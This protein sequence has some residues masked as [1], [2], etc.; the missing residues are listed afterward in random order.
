MKLSGLASAL[1]AP[2]YMTV[3]HHRGHR[4]IA[5]QMVIFSGD[6]EIEVSLLSMRECFLYAV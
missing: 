6:D 4:Q 5:D 1:V 2:G 3:K